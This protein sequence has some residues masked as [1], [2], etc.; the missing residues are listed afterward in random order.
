MELKD[1]NTTN[2]LPGD[3]MEQAIAY[4]TFIR[5]LLRSDAGATWWRLFG[6]E[7]KVP[8]PLN[9]YAACGMPS[10]E[11]NDYSFGRMELNIER[12]TITLHYI[13][14]IDENGRIRI[15]PGDTTLGAG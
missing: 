6:F 13:Y 10:N 8:E 7:G 5:E 12:D 4:A 14:F 1:E 15:K 2:E 9:L 11:N 3:A